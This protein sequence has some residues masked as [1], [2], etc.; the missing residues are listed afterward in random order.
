L[1][2]QELDSDGDNLLLERSGEAI[3]E[4]IGWGFHVGVDI[5]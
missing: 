3:A 5:Y 2:V 1:G 4:N